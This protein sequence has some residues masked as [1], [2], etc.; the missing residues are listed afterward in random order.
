ML[1]GFE[2][3]FSNL[4]YAIDTRKNQVENVNSE[5]ELLNRR[6]QRIQLFTQQQLD[7]EVEQ[8]QQEINQTLKQQLQRID[9]Q[10][11]SQLDE[12]NYDYRQSIDHE[13]GELITRRDG[14]Y[15]DWNNERQVVEERFSALLLGNISDSRDEKS[16]LLAELDTLKKEMK[17]AIAEA[18][19]LTRETT[20]R[21]YR[22]L[23][24]DKNRQL[25][26][27]TLGYLGG[28]ALTKQASMEDQLRQQIAFI[29]QK[30]EGRISE[31]TERIETK[32]LTLIDQNER[33]AKLEQQLLSAAESN[34]SKFLAIKVD[35]DRELKA[36]QQNKQ[37]EL[38][39]I[40]A[41]T[42]KIEDDIFLLRNKQRN[43]GAE[44]NQLINQ[45]Q[46]YR[47]AMYAFGKQSPADV[48]R[49]MVGIVALLWFGSL[50][51]VASVTGVMLSLAGFY[52]KRQLMS[53]QAN[54]EQ[55]DRHEPTASNKQE[56]EQLKVA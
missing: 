50:A 6:Q 51:L 13:I 41:K 45:N 1:N 17:Y 24:T 40:K 20:E 5:I 55:N 30:Y 42:D 26:Q 28:D 49:Q 31:I 16:R 56:Q 36:Y 33:N 34:K 11:Q 29:K 8:R 54:R 43:I 52:L 32:K 35:L 48:D 3:N 9:R 7:T 22:R 23:I 19:F 18:S 25:E 12:V 27:I 47:M 53:E 44:I 15:N 21:K 2:R 10:T 39:E 14:Y 46:V 37:L 38:A 4:N